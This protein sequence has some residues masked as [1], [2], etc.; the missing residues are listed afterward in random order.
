[1]G[2]SKSSLIKK[3]YLC[4]N[5]SKIKK[6]EL[7]NTAFNENLKTYFVV[8]DDETWQNLKIKPNPITRDGQFIN[9]KEDISNYTTINYNEWN[10]YFNIPIDKL[11]LYNFNKPILLVGDNYIPRHYGEFNF[12]D[13]KFINTHKVVLCSNSELSKIIDLNT[14]EVLDPNYSKIYSTIPIYPE[15]EKQHIIDNYINNAP[16]GGYALEM[17]GINIFIYGERHTLHFDSYAGNLVDAASVYNKKKKIKALI[18]F[19]LYEYKARSDME[20]TIVDRVTRYNQAFVA[21][22]PNKSSLIKIND[23]LN[24]IYTGQYN[25]ELKELIADN[26]EFEILLNTLKDYHAKFKKIP[27]DLQKK[28]ISKIKL[29]LSFESENSALN[30]AVHYAV[31][32]DLPAVIDIYFA[33]LEKSDVLYICGYAHAVNILGILIMND[34]DFEAAVHHVFINETN[35]FVETNNIIDKYL[36]YNLE[37]NYTLKRLKSFDSL[38][39]TLTEIADNN[40][41]ACEVAGNCR[42]SGGIPNNLYIYII[43]AFIIVAVILI[44][45]FGRTSYNKPCYDGLYSYNTYNYN[46]MYS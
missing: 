16:I 14:F 27:D 3:I 29:Y 21:I 38:K 13:A 41:V 4:F 26:N 36:G 1:M 45:M 6:V 43:I 42:V 12:E 28:I 44:L 17:F 33:S 40:A 35:E 37:N 18:E 15:D 9:D 2:S 7:F 30:N 19:G 39:N 25:N 32:V 23:I 31:L 20:I 10:S 11:T 5:K 22:N 46:S 8:I 34:K 24:V